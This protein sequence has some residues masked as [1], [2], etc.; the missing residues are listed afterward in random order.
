VNKPRALSSIRHSTLIHILD[1]DSLLHI[2]HIYRPVLVD[3]DETNDD[4]VLLGGK[5]DR[6]R[7]WY[8]PAQVCQRWRYL[9]LGSASHLGLHLVCTYGTPVAN[10]LEHSPPLPLIIDHFGLDDHNITADEEEEIMLALQHRD[11]VRRIRLDASVPNLQ[12]LILAMDE[13]FPMLESVV[14]MPPDK[15]H[16]ALI[17]PTTF[18]AP[19][20]RRLIL[21][22]FAFPIGSSLLT[23]GVGLVTLFLDYIFPS[24]YFRP[25]YLLQRLSLMPQLEILGISFHSPVSNR[26]ITRQLWHTPVREHVTL[27]NLRWFAYRGVSTYLEA[28]LP[29]LASPRLKKLQI[30]FFN[31]LTLSVPHLLQ[32]MNSITNLKFSSTEIIFDDKAIHVRLYPRE[33]AALDASF[34]RVGCT[35]FEWQV[36][37][38]AQLSDQLST[39]LS[40]VVYLTFKYGKVNSSSE[41]NNDTNHTRWR[42]ILRSFSNVKTLRVPNDLVKDISRSLQLDEGDES[43]TELLPELKELEY[44]T[45]DDADD[46]FMT[47]IDAR[48]NAGRPV[49]LLRG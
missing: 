19:L 17:L 39:V 9:I 37:S 35:N 26:E 15:H 43:P 34:I 20:L 2:F 11:R 48:Q 41:S 22:N 28:F 7:W 32:F 42:K 49:T 40:A 46:E 18:R 23:T 4:I 36:A 12:K 31:Q 1:D 29:R 25:N 8:K 21:V 3:E 16:T 33:G 24:V 45:T 13:E 14:L 10:M 27:P 47:F 5:W 38:A 44:A 6:E 30:I